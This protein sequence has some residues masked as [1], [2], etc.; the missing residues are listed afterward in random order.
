MIVE[1]AFINQKYIYFSLLSH[2]KKIINIQVKIKTDFLLL[3][4]CKKELI[5]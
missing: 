5:I 2:Y 4:N 1:L 3:N